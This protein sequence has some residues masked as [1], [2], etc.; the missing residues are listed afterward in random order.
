MQLLIITSYNSH[1][2]LYPSL[3]M[4]WIGNIEKDM[5]YM[6]FEPKCTNCYIDQITHNIV[7]IVIHDTLTLTWTLI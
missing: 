4:H 6:E 7:V 3:F 2:D 1:L 5:Y